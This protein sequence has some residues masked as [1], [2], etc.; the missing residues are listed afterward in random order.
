MEIVLLAVLA[1]LI[2]GP[3]KLPEIGRSIG[4]G[5][6]DFKESI[7]GTGVGDVF[8]GVNEVRTRGQPDEHGEGVRPGCR[9]HPGC[10]RCGEER[11]QP[12]RG[13]WAPS[14]GGQACCHG[15][16]THRPL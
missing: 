1:A 16:K 5:M 3:A 6:K 4:R 14:E 12:D 15:V 11:R 10:G 8:E 13:A 2:F 7:D 9:R